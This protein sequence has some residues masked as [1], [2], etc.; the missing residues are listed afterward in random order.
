MMPALRV[1]LFSDVHGNLAA[2]RAVAAAIKREPPVDYIV[3]AGDHLQG[4]PRP[5]EVW[6]LLTRRGWILIKGNEDEALLATDPLAGRA[7][8]PYDSAFLAQVAWTRDQV[9]RNVLARIAALPSQWRIE[10]PAGPLLVV[11]ASPRSLDDRAGAAHNSDAD[12]LLAYGGTG[13]SAIAFGHYH[14]NFVRATPFALLINVASVGLPV[15]GRALASFTILTASPLSWVVEQRQVPYRQAAELAAARSRG[16]P[17]WRREEDD[18]P[19]DDGES[20]A[21]VG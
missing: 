2:L 19:E 20:T 4:G 6:E 21:S 15:H 1:A 12:V 14:Q 5:R 8:T 3:V 7:P 10:T 18:D 16:M 13:A 17:P 9:G 11:H